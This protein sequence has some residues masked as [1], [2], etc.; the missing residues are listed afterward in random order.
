M[1]PG[2]TTLP[3]DRHLLDDAVRAEPVVDRRLVRVL[4]R[5]P[6]DVEGFLVEVAVAD[7]RRLGPLDDPVEVRLL[8]RQALRVTPAHQTCRHFSASAVVLNLTNAHPLLFFVSRSQTSVTS[9]TAPN[10][11]QTPF[12]ASSR[13]AFPRRAKNSVV[14]GSELSRFPYRLRSPAMTRNALFPDRA[15]P[16]YFRT[17]KT[18]A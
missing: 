13:I 9:S 17:P 18:M 12:S 5:D 16:V 2:E 10:C 4:R 1:S 15:L 8:P 14:I 11:S 7:L 3:D 6:R